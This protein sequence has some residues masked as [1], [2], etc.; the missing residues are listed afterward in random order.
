MLA[1][2]PV[3]VVRSVINDEVGTRILSKDNTSSAQHFANCADQS[4]SRLQLFLHS[5]RTEEMAEP[6][7]LREVFKV[8][9]HDADRTAVLYCVHDAH[10]FE[11]IH[12]DNVG[13]ECG[14]RV[15]K[16]AGR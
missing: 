8:D 3:R 1:P 7:E 15:T 12:K 16:R 14:K 13:M 2:V 5:S 10:A 6:V 9:G 4:E 11:P